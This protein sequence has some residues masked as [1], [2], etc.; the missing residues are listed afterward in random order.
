MKVIFILRFALKFAFQ[1]IT[2]SIHLLK[3]KSINMFN[4]KNKLF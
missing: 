3:F 2:L 4:N 1:I